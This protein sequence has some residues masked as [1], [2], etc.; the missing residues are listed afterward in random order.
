MKKTGTYYRKVERVKLRANSRN[1][2]HISGLL[3]LFA[4]TYK[5]EGSVQQ[6]DDSTSDRNLVLLCFT[7]YV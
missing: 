7:Q 2:P 6:R 5:W 3:S 1:D 4:M